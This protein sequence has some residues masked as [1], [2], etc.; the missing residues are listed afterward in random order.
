M[1]GHSHES[2]A[3]CLLRA[4]ESSVSPPCPSPPHPHSHP[5]PHPEPVQSSKRSCL[6]F[7]LTWSL[8]LT[9]RTRLAWNSMDQVI[10]LPQFLSK[11]SRSLKY[12][13]SLCTWLSYFKLQYSLQNKSRGWM[14]PTAWQPALSVVFQQTFS[15]GLRTHKEF[16]KGRQGHTRKLTLKGWSAASTT[17]KTCKVTLEK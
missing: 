14:Q 1:R 5:H 4:S 2:L 10:L 8:R 16:S 3:F 15:R 7:I 9:V 12:S 11:P 6:G 17:L 13:M